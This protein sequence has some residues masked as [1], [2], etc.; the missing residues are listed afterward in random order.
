[1]QH[2]IT[3]TTAVAGNASLLAQLGKQT[4][5]ESHGPSAAQQ[6]I[7]EYTARNYTTTVFDSLIKDATNLI[8][9]LNV[10]TKAAGYSMMKV[11]AP[12]PQIASSNVAKLDRLYLLKEF[13]DLKLGWRLLQFNISLAKSQ[14]QNAMWLYAWKGNERAVNFYKKAGFEII[15]SHDFKLTETHANPNHLMLLEFSSF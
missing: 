13:H 8:Y 5:V 9:I 12:H 10:G 2:E 6:V 15:G 1:M 11:N 7:E 14:Q 3:I 4:F